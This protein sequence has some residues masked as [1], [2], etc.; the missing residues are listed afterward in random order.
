MGGNTMI[1]ETM[2]TM[3]GQ[4]FY[5]GGYP[6]PADKVTVDGRTIQEIFLDICDCDLGDNDPDVKLINDYYR[7]HLLAPCWKLGEI[8]PEQIM[9]ADSEAFYDI[10]I[11][12][13][14]DP[15]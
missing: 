11:E 7:Y 8:T 1:I 12:L 4:Q 2:P 9:A 15:I 3:F 10:C 14:I 13:A 5:P 6:V